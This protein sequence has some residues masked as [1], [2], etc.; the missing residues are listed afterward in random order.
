MTALNLN[1]QIL[2]VGGGAAGIATAASLLA[3]D[4]SLQI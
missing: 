3:R 1:C 4:A 2:I